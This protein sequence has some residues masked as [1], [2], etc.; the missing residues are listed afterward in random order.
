MS[1]ATPVLKMKEPMKTNEFRKSSQH[2]APGGYE[3][4]Y[5]WRVER[6]EDGLF[7]LHIRSSPEHEWV[8]AD[9]R[10]VGEEDVVIIAEL[11]RRALYQ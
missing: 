9:F 3:D 7:S 2:S 11:L 6:T 10:D 8:Y 4:V 1:L 5:E